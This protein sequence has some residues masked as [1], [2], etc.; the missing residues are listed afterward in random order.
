M[1]GHIVIVGYRPKPGKDIAL[2]ELMRTHLPRLKAMR[3]VTDRASIIMEAS[4]GILIEVF[5]W[6]SRAAMQKAHENPAVLKMW[7]EYAAVCDYIPIGSIKEAADLF[8]AFR[9]FT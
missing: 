5:E 8:S 3:L 1:E 9:P 7:E 6:T 4:D 2:R